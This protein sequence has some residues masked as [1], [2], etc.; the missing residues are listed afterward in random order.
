MEA[1]RQIVVDNIRKC[2]AEGRFNDK[3]EPGDPTLDGS[4]IQKL[5]NNIV[6]TRGSITYWVYNQCARAISMWYTKKIGRITDYE[7]LEK[8]KDITGAA[9][10]TSNHFGPTE[11]CI[12][13]N[14]SWKQHKWVM[15]AISQD[16]NFAMKGMAGFLLRYNDLIPISSDRG[17]MVNHFEQMLSNAFEKGHYVLM[18][19]EQEMWWN[20]RKVRPP[21]RGAYLYAAKYNVPI[22]S[23]FVEIITSE[24]KRAGRQACYRLHVLDPIYPDPSKTVKANSIS[25]MEKDYRQKTEAYEKAYSKKLDYT[26]TTWDIAGLE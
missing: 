1:S 22:I 7:G 16:T 8:I 26:F 5:L 24:D 21:K 6:K 25:M 18:Y 14:M 11:N 17:Y 3:V 23:C 19:P 4:D 15:D 12:L 10:V 2:V 9:I 20:Y 13:R